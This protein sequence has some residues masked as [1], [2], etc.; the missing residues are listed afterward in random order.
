MAT[1]VISTV[2]IAL[3]C[4]VATRANDRFRTH[5]RLPMQWGWHGQV[6]WTA[7]RKVALAFMPALAVLVLGLHSALSMITV[8]RPGQAH[9]V[10]PILI[11]T[12][13]TLLAIQAFHLWIIART[14]K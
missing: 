9:L 4:L 13:L 10:L 8:P 11:L 6:N 3:M 12:G 5:A 1:I 14:L 2:V 7:P